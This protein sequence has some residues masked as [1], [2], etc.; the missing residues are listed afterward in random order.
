MWFG[1]GS[2]NEGADG[3][4]SGEGVSPSPVG[5][6]SWRGLCPLP[7]KK[8]CIFSFEMVHFDAF[9]RTFRSTVIVPMM[10]SS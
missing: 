10:F 7:I 5:V 2:R 6:G 1:G 9:W 4:G 8:F 3:G